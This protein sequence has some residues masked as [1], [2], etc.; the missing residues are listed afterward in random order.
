MWQLTSFEIRRAQHQYA[1]KP[2]FGLV[3]IAVY[4][5]KL[6]ERRTDRKNNNTALLLSL[7]FVPSCVHA[8]SSD[9]HKNGIHSCIVPI[10]NSRYICQYGPPV[11]SARTVARY[12]VLLRRQGK[13][14]LHVWRSLE[15]RSAMDAE[16]CVGLG[17]ETFL[18][19]ADDR[20]AYAVFGFVY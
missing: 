18:L 16:P 1:L 4:W 11:W 7:Y 8:V 3:G 9:K 17:S 10:S 19:V 15:A 20:S 5:K 6:R 2:S 13:Q 12:R 14:V